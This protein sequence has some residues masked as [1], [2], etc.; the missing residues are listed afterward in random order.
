MT[1]DDL[2]K[3]LTETYEPDEQLVWQTI[4]L[5][6]VENGVEGATPDLWEDF[7]ENQEYYGELADEISEA[8]F[9]KFFEYVEENA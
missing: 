3:F 1:R 8:V 5:D 2:V 4:C 9:N 7:I 6:D